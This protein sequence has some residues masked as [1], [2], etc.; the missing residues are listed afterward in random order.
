[1]IYRFLHYRYCVQLIFLFFLPLVGWRPFLLGIHSLTVQSFQFGE[2][3]GPVDDSLKQ[4]LGGSHSS[5]KGGVRR[6]QQKRNALL[7]FS[8]TFLLHFLRTGIC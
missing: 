6:F 5:L 1:M 7:F 2:V 8:L 4:L 3:G